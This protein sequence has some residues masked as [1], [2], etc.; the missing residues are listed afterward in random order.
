MRG[1]L[2]ALRTAVG[3]YA[4]QHVGKYPSLSNF[5]QE[6]TQY[7]DETGNFKSNP[8]A[9]HIYGPYMLKLPTLR[10]GEGPD[11]G[12]GN[13]KAGGAPAPSIGWIYNETA[14]NIRANSGTAEDKMGVLY[15]DY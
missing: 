3:L 14:G 10:V 15:T 13:D 2:Y 4:A 7:T 9:T 11:N 5:R 12:K 8:D 1:D 6:V